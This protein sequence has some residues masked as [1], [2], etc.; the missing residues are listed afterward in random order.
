MRRTRLLA[1]LLLLAVMGLGCTPRGPSS[2]G[3]GPAPAGPGTGPQPVAEKPPVDDPKE[4]ERLQGKWQVIESDDLAGK[5]D[6]KSPLFKER[7]FHYV[8]SG[9]KVSVYRYKKV[10]KE[11]TYQ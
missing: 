4:R 9:D 5:Q 10:D 11:G 6:E 1:P 7:D 3:S 2:A 8:F